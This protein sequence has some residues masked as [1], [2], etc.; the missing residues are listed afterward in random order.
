MRTI[1]GT[2][3]SFLRAVEL[4]TSEL[5]LLSDGLHELVAGTVDVIVVRHAFPEETMRRVAQAIDAN[6]HGF[7]ATPQED[8]DVTREQVFVYGDGIA[9]NFV[10]GSGP[11]PERYLTNAETW[12]RECRRLFAGD[13]D[14]ETRMGEIF[15]ALA[16]ER[17]VRVPS[18]SDAR[19]YCPSTVRKVPPG[20]GIAFHVDTYGYREYPPLQQHLSTFLSL[21]N[22]ISFF[23]TMVPS[24]SGGQPH[25]YELT[26]EESRTQD[27]VTA[28][29]SVREQA[30]STYAYQA[31]ELA[32]GDLFIFV[33]GRYWHLVSEVRGSTPRWT[34]GGFMGFGLDGRSV[35]YWG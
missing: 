4:E 31:F 2:P 24:E 34:I 19:T 17:E 23:T 9:P 21:T 13:P 18:Y 15:T 1:E 14:Y 35:Y 32:S 6:E 7:V 10:E 20:H 26:F 11:P 30:A 27:I 3:K 33:G 16:G 5:N 8:V 12:R 22:Q 28:R 25:V 29:D